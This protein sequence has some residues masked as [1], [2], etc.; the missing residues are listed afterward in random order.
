MYIVWVPCYV[1]V[2]WTPHYGYAH[3]NASYARIYPDVN[4]GLFMKS[5][6]SLDRIMVDA[7]TLVGKIRNSKEFANE[8]MG[9]A[10]ES[11][12]S[13]VDSLIKSTGV[14]T[15]V[16]AE[17]NPDRLKLHMSSSVEQMECCQL[18]IQLRWR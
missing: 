7:Q 10:K 12:Q 3:W 5:A 14:S 1:P 6:S 13:K 18:T 16:K 4:E 9:A 11:N 15:P 17:Y 2:V 8:L